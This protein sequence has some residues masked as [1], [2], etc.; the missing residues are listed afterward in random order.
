MKIL[1]TEDDP[2]QRML[3]D[4]IL[5]RN[6]YEVAVAACGTD[7]LQVLETQ[8]DVGLLISDIM[9]PDMDGLELL[10]RVKANPGLFDLPIIL[11]TALTDVE[12]IKAAARL[13]CGY[14]IVKPLQVQ[15]V[16]QRVQEALDGRKMIL[17]EAGLSQQKLG[18]DAATLLTLAVAFEKLVHA[19]IVLIEA[20]LR[21]PAADSDGVDLTGLHESAI[22]LGAEKLGNILVDIQ[23][24]NDF[25]VIMLEEY[26]LLLRELKV[27]SLRLARMISQLQPWHDAAL[28]G[29]A[30]D[31]AA[32]AS[33]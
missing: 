22:L 28:S 8:P 27:L 31:A 30:G 24:G 33:R 6:H 25:S 7:A 15:V 10:R 9:M 16:L 21:S 5:K 3:L 26:Q 11:C 19:Q 20:K 29:H 14:Y 32:D 4:N 2:I 23:S 18:V 12:H 17:R 13:G 1:I